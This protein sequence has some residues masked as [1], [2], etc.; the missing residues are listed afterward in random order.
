MYN[1]LQVWSWHTWWSSLHVPDST[2]RLQVSPFSLLLLSLLFIRKAVYKVQIKI[3]SD[4]KMLKRFLSLIYIHIPY[5]IVIYID[6]CIYKKYNINRTI[7]N[8]YKRS[9]LTSLKTARCLNLEIL[10][11][12]FM[13]KVKIFVKPYYSA[14]KCSLILCLWCVGVDKDHRKLVAYMRYPFI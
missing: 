14:S 10:T 12:V 7:K 6:I 9:S 8:K 3:R 2:N 4:L 5:I 13:C 1:V 11:R